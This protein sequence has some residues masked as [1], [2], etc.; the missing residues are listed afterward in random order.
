[1]FLNKQF[2]YKK[3]KCINI[4]VSELCGST[5]EQY[6]DYNF[7]LMKQIAFTLFII[8]LNLPFAI[9]HEIA[10]DAIIHNNSYIDSGLAEKEVLSKAINRQTDEQSFHLF[11]HGK[12][13]QLLLKNQWLGGDDL[14]AFLQPLLKGKTQLN[15][16]GCHFAQGEKG[17]AAVAYLKTALGVS[18]AASDDLTGIDGDWDLEIGTNNSNLNI[19]NYAYNLQDYDIGTHNGQSLSVCSGNFYDDGG[20]AGNYANNTG[21]QEVTFCSDN[22]STITLDFTSFDV[23]ANAT[24]N[25]DAMYIT[26]LAASTTAYSTYC[27][28]NSPGTVTS[29]GNCLRIEFYSDSADNR[30]GWAASISCGTTVLPTDFCCPNNN[31]VLNASLEGDL[32]PTESFPDA[33]TSPTQNAITAN[34]TNQWQ[35]WFSESSSTFDFNVISDATRASDGEEF[36]YIP[37]LS[38]QTNNICL[39][40]RQIYFGDPAADCGTS[41]YVKPN[42]RYVICFDWVPFDKDSPN[43]TT[44]TTTPNVE[45]EEYAAG[46]AFTELLM[47]DNTG[48]I[49]GP[50]A[51]VSWANVA[52][53]WEQAC[54]SFT[55]VNIPPGEFLRS[56]YSHSKDDNSGM[57]IDNIIFQEIGMTDAGISNIACGSSADQIMFDL[58]PVTNTAGVPNLM[59]NVSAPAGF[60]VAPTQGTYGQTTSFTL[61][62]TTDGDFTDGTPATVDITITDAVN[63]DCSLVETITNNCMPICTNPTITTRDSTICNGNMVDVALL[64]STTNGTLTFHSASPPDNS[65]ELASTTLTPTTNTTIYVLATDGSCTSTSSLMITHA[66]PDMV[67]ICDN[68]SNSATFTAQAGLTGVEWFN[69]ANTSVGTGDMLTVNSNTTGMGDGSDSFYYT[70]TDGSGCAIGLCCP[71]EVQ[72][73]VC[74]GCTLSLNTTQSTCTDNGD[75]TFTATYDLT[76]N[77]SNPPA[78]GDITIALTGDGTLNTSTVSAVTIAG[79]STTTLTGAFTVPADGAGNT[80]ITATFDDETACT[81]TATFKAP[82]PCPTDVTACGGTNC[83]GGNVFED[84]N[85]NGADDAS[86]P[87]VQGVQIQV[88]DCNNTLVGTGYSD[89]EGDWQVCGLTD[90][91]AYRIEHVLP[92]TVAC[93]AQPTHV[94]TDNMSDVQFLTAPACTKFSV[95]SPADYCETNPDVALP[96]FE[97]GLAVG[98]NNIAMVGFPYN[99]T[100]NT[101]TKDNLADFEEIGAT[102][103]TGYQRT[104]SRLF[105]GALLKRHAGLNTTTGLGGLH[106][107]DMSD[108]AMP[109]TSL[110]LQGASPASGA[111]LDFGTVNRSSAAFG[112]PASN[113]ELSALNTSPNIDLDA[114]NKVGIVGM[115]DIEVDETDNRLW[116]VNLHQRSLFNMDISGSLPGTI[117]NYDLETISGYP[118]CP[119][120]TNTATTTLRINAGGGAYTDANGNAWI[121]DAHFTGGGTFNST[122]VNNADNPYEGTIEAAIYEDYRSNATG[123]SYDVPVTNGRYHVI[124]HIRNRGETM[125]G[126]QLME[127]TVEGQMRGSNIDIYERENI[128]ERA[129]TIQLVVDVSDGNLDLDLASDNGSARVAGI[130][131]LPIASGVSGVVR[132]WALSFHKG[133]GYLGVVCD[134]STSMRP[135]D[136]I[137]TVLSFDPN[138]VAAGFTTEL[139]FPM[140]Y[141]R[142]KQTQQTAPD[143]LWQVWREDITMLRNLTVTVAKRSFEPQPILSDITFTNNGSMVIGFMD[144]TGHQEGTLNHRPFA[145]NT[146]IGGSGPR[147]AG[148]ILHACYINGA[149]VLEQGNGSACGT[150][151]LGARIKEQS[152]D[153]PSGNGEYYFDDYYD[154]ARHTE[155]ATGGLAA[156]R[157]GSEVLTTVWDPTTNVFSQGVHWYSTTAGILTDSFEIVPNNSADASTF[158]KGNG[159]GDPEFLCSPAPLEIGNYVWCDSLENGIQDACERGIAG[160]NVSLYDRNGALVGVTETS[161]SGNYVFNQT[162]VDTTGVNTDGSAMNSFTGMSYSTQYFIVFGNTQFT[163]GEFTVGGDMYGITSVVNAG[164][165]DNIDSDVDGSSLTAGSLGARPD[166]LPFIDMTTNAQGCGDHKYDLG[167]TCASCFEIDSLITDRIVC[168]GD[169]VDSLAVTTTFMNPDSIAFVYFTSQ[170][171]DSIQIYTAGIGIDT[172]QIASGNDTVT[173]TNVAFPANT[174]SSPVLYYVYAIAQPSPTDNTCRPYEE[175]LVTVNPLSTGTVNYTGCQGD[176]HSITVNSV[177][178]NE[179]NPSGSQT[180]TNQY[181][182]D[183]VVTINLVF[184]DTIQTPITQEI[185]QGDSYTFNGQTLTMAGTYRDTLTRTNTCDSIIVLTLNVLDTI[186]TPITQEICQGDSYTFNG[187]SLTM[188]GTYRDTLTRTNTCD[189]IIVLTLN[190]L[191]TIQTPITQEICQGDSYTFNGQSLT[192]AGTYRD[193]LTRTN[194]CDSFI[195]LTLNVLDTIQTPITQEICQGDSYTFNGQAL[196]MAGT[197]R[198]T[199]TRTNTCDSFIVLTLNVLDTI[200]TPITQEICQGDSYTFNGQALTMAGT[201]RDTLTRTNTCDSFIVLTLNVLDTI[202][203]PIT[204]EICQGDSY[205]FNGQALTMAGTYR[206]TLTRTNTCDSFI[207]LTLNVLDTIQTPITQEICQGDSYTF[208]GQALTMA[209]T[210]RDTLTRTNTCDSFIVLTLNVLD[211]IQT[212]ITQEICQ[213]DSYTFNGQ[214]LTMAGTYRDTLTRTNTC[215]SFIVLTLNVLDTIQT[216]ITQEICQGDSYTFNGQA[217]TMAGTYRDTLTRTNTCDSFIVLTLNVLD[218]IQTPITQE[219]CQGDSYT[220]NGQ[221]LTMAGTYRDTLTRT[222]TCDSFIVLTL[223]VLDTIQ[224]PI[225]QEICQGDSYTFNGQSLTMAGT[226]R[227]TLTRTNTCDSFIV[228]TLNVLDT[229]QTP[230]TQEICQGDSYTFNGQSLT[231][232]G[233]Y[234]DTLTRTNTCDSFI[235]L[236]LNVLDTIQTPI[237]QEICQGDSYTFNGQTLTMAG[238]YRDTLTRTNTCDSF[239]VLTLNVNAKPSITGI[240]TSFC[241]TQTINLST[242]ISGTTIGTVTYGTSFGSYPTTIATDVSVSSTTTYY[243][244]DSNETTMCVDTAVIVVSVL[245]CD[246]G[247]LPDTSTTTNAGDYQ[248]TSANNGPVHVITSGLSLGSTVDAETDGQPSNNALGDDA[249]E[250]GT[251]IWESLDI[252]PG[253]ILRLPL[254]YTNTTGNTAYIEAWVDWNG[255]G[256]FEDDN[257]MVFD[258][259]DTGSS[260]YD[261]IAITVP[262]DAV[263]GQFLG[264]RIRIS[265]TDNMTPYGKINSGEIEDYLIGL[266]CP[267]QICVPIQSTINRKD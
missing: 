177:V 102:W 191:D 160:I 21:V 197:Y 174:G 6:S 25:F 60:T 165:N 84:F 42:T 153:G 170:Q 88:Y 250:D 50:K 44:N 220:F 122:T 98:N 106:M 257:E 14:V 85:C 219:I 241:G 135:E 264:L 232:A 187:Q 251:E 194:T 83:I 158:G 171:T 184:Q 247:D 147:V 181:G 237:T 243:V 248:T 73:E 189:S 110:N 27:G 254:N 238:T 91:T 221:S 10:N 196:T 65:N 36:A 140:D 193:T 234:R 190:V 61:T 125:E 30:P 31:Q 47:Y 101:G 262:I 52:T 24:C 192:M 172:V 13:G 112:L 120:Y 71:I 99:S 59:Y 151:D 16:Y 154:G 244:R 92:E 23:E 17:R 186:Q 228:L 136:L 133:R 107:I 150:N 97:N 260:A 213:G 143:I 173:I 9:A 79:G 178:Y 117:N 169:V 218:T 255:D 146:D 62:T 19:P 230:I 155:I 231:M 4:L 225:T 212:P 266:D 111:T 37:Q 188:A 63:A 45:Y 77:W 180:L 249:D 242:L 161:A 226:Y 93:W 217:L 40:H 134:A 210:Y 163:T 195:V 246:W 198:D 80:T 123:Y 258:V 223:N 176:G 201:Y 259:S 208:N 75:G 137:A 90:G 182:C 156:L 96:C 68:A 64:A 95:S 227:D 185:C 204:Q 138:N 1:M 70:A 69:S 46:G 175:I 113:F 129:S 216:P 149:F 39:S 148:D 132:P 35:G 141:E 207:V 124:L 51:G 114:F 38:G 236:T 41:N 28:T 33:T 202:Q 78:T 86:E 222:N 131:I 20:A 118:T 66:T 49:I 7:G 205:T 67:M 159:L 81:A 239:I 215:D 54:V 168:S 57:L 53:S 142:E 162:N 203:T 76:L 87:G 130:E 127:V 119:V 164:S 43:G 256:D 253:G 34:T 22:G 121:A 265:H 126:E 245:D 206:D 183:S 5:S 128:S 240:D 224:T 12:A 3:L 11:S 139:S 263:T 18:V 48:N 2:Y 103:G 115:G 199:L 74:A 29:T 235:V 109:V 100:G 116:G 229:I 56:W 55:T 152:D 166:G 58:N 200:Q 94:G 233:T 8:L 214:A 167:V 145:G 157:N 209:G 89:S 211:T 108:P 267:T 105:A 252:Y 179:G 104:Q 26:D 261:R 82:V 15:I 144:R 32:V 72:T